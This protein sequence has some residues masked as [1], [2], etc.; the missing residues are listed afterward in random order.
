MQNSKQNPVCTILSYI[1]QFTKGEI[2]T[3]TYRCSQKVQQH[4]CWAWCF[5]GV[6]ANYLVIKTNIFAHLQNT[7]DIKQFISDNQYLVKCETHTKKLCLIVNMNSCYRWLHKN[8]I[9]CALS[10]DL[11]LLPIKTKVHTSHHLYIIINLN[12]SWIIRGHNQ[13]TGEE[14]FHSTLIVNANRFGKLILIASPVV[15]ANY[16]FWMFYL[17]EAENALGNDNTRIFLAKKIL[18]IRTVFIAE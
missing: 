7:C 10:N 15:C 17:F 2:L 3:K 18:S 5:K 16:K 14:L 1:M 9:L 8:Y 6:V 11:Y 12:R 4:L 13:I